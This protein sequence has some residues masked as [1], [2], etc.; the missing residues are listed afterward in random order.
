M[1]EIGPDNAIAISIAESV[2]RQQE[3]KDQLANSGVYIHADVEE[4][5]TALPPS[6]FEMTKKSQKEVKKVLEST[7]DESRDL[8]KDDTYKSLKVSDWGLSVHKNT[9]F[10]TFVL[11]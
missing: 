5:Y 10:L 7:E 2:R 3:V 8:L 11:V 1:N 9:F 6:I 4:M